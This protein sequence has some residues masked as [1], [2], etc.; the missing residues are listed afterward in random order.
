MSG[1]EAPDV[2]SDPGALFGALG[3]ELPPAML[4]LTEETRRVVLAAMDDAAL[5]GAKTAFDA[6]LLFFCQLGMHHIEEALR[7]MVIQPMYHRLHTLLDE[8]R[9]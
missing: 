1:N 6:V 7:E 4:A 2:P 9:G 3:S 5:M 8:R